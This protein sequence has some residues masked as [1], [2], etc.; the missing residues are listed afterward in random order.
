MRRRWAALL[1]ALGGAG[2]I[3]RLEAASN[4]LLVRFADPARLDAVALRAL[5]ARGI[6]ETGPGTPQVL[7][8]LD[9]GGL[10]AALAH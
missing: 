2:N 4:R 6:A 1:A 3:Q 5:G 8:A 9:A 10:A 7:L